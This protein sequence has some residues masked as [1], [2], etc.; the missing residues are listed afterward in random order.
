MQIPATG[1]HE[2]SLVGFESTTDALTLD[3][4][5]V[6]LEGQKQAVSIKLEGLRELTRDGQRIAAVQMEAEDGE[7]LT[8]ELS[9]NQLH[10]ICEWNNFRNRERQTRSYTCNCDALQVEV[11]Q[12]RDGQ[13]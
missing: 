7:V 9:P 5:G 12:R 13:D 11:Q 6:L 3:L 4:E 2:S 8:L 10:L 1:F